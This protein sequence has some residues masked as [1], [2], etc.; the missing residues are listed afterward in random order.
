MARRSEVK[1]LA[2]VVRPDPPYELN[3]EESEVWRAIVDGLPA[4]HFQPCNFYLLTALCKHVATR[5]R[6][7]RLIE[8]ELKK[9]KLD[10]GRLS[11]LTA[12]RYRESS[13]VRVLSSAMRLTQQ[14]VYL[15]QTAARRIK[16]VT[17]TGANMI[18][19]PWFKGDGGDAE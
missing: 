11:R 14:S 13:A 4:D 19:S 2:V 10:D 16:G 3:E 18:D 1:V 17:A 15:P 9:R 5:R 6:F 12:M 7:D 8:L